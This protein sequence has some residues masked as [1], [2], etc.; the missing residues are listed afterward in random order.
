MQNT[1]V[2]TAPMPFIRD[3]FTW[4]AYLLFG[5]FAYLVISFGPILPFLRAR[6]ALSYAQG[7]LHLSA[8]AL[9]NVLMGLAGERLVARV[10]QRGALLLGGSGLALGTLGLAGGKHMAITLGSAFV[11][12]LLGGAIP[13]VIQAA[14]ADHHGAQR[15]VALTE[16]NVG[17]MMCAVLVP[18]AVGLAE[19]SGAGWPAALLA[20]V[21]VWLLLALLLIQQPLPLVPP[22][23]HS[24]A[25]GEQQRALPSAFWGYWALLFLGVGVEW[26]ISFWGPTFLSSAAGMRAPAAS[27]AM[28][29]FFA[30]MVAGRLA[31]SSLVRHHALRLLLLVS[32]AL[33]LCGFLLLWL[34]PLLWLN[35][36][37]LALA[38][39]GVAGL[40]PLALSAGI[41]LAAEHTMLASSRSSMAAGLAMLLLPALLGWLAD[42]TTLSGALGM[43]IVLLAVSGGI[44]LA[45][46]A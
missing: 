38:G 9:G 13:V 12:G 3:R 4:L 37:G 31:A 25:A 14:L 46:K 20:A 8:L 44:T 16:A 19:R 23:P 43:V 39:L 42:V 28:S 35:L 30:A 34:A 33:A 2:L 27:A 41:G 40:F 11:M 17:V 45:L 22:V 6:L 10:G 15:E 24:A 1:T 7:G 36:V 26:C 18:L 32:Q 21:G 5:Y 29:L